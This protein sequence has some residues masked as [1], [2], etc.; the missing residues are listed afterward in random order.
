MVLGVATGI[1][2]GELLLA[3]PLSDLAI[4]IAL[5]A[6]VAM[7]V[8]V[9]FGLAPVIPIQAGVSAIL[10]LAFG[11]TTAGLARFADVAVGATVGLLFSQIL[12]T[13]D[14]VRL[15]EEA[16]RRMLHQLAQG[17]AEDAEALAERNRVK[18][19]EGLSHFIAAHVSL[20][21]LGVGI[22]SARSISRWSLR[23]RI[24]ARKVT[25]LAARYD[26]LAIRLFASTLLFGEALADALRSGDEPPPWLRDRVVQVANRCEALAD[27]G[28]GFA[29]IPNDRFSEGPAAASWRTCIAY[30]YAV[31][32]TLQALRQASETP[33]T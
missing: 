17:F 12:L 5:N 1:A 21:A 25:N 19:Q 26:R 24:A 9:S 11:P 29:E 7:M 18:A 15:I 28:K 27:G 16:A 3:I 23:G 13:P 2:V 33:R 30:L 31:E 20:D 10:V 4:R 6:F 22:E 8:A 32:D 14:P